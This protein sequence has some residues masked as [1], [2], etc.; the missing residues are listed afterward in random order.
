VVSNIYCVVFYFVSLGLVLLIIILFRNNIHQT[1]DTHFP[2]FRRFYLTQSWHTTPWV[3]ISV[4]E[5]RRGNQK[6]TIQRNWQHR[7]HKTK[8]DKAQTVHN[9]CWTPLWFISYIMLM[10]WESRK[11]CQK[12]AFLP[13]SNFYVIYVFHL[14][15]KMFICFNIHVPCIVTKYWYISLHQ[16]E[17]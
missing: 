6:W 16:W 2:R 15:G 12:F 11:I 3:E 17:I 8:E 4:R 9:M 5:Y 14:N 7:V 13:V 10:A 1:R